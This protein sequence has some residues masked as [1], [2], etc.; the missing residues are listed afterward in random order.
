MR[1]ALLLSFSVLCP[2]C[3][4]PALA[5]PSAPTALTARS[6]S[7][8][9][10]D[11][12]WSAVSNGKQVL[13]SATNAAFTAGS[14]KRTLG[15]EV[16]AYAH[17]ALPGGTTYWYRVKSNGNG[18]SPWSNV[19]TGTTAPA[20]LAVR[21]LSPTSLEI[22][23]TANPANPSI[24]G[25]TVRFSTSAG[26]PA[27]TAYQ[28]AGPGTT[29]SYVA[30]ALVA[31]ATYFVA[32]KAEGTPD[33]AFSAPASVTLP[34]A[35]PAGVPISP[36]FFG[37]NAWMP[38][39]IGLAHKWGDLEQLLCGAGYTPGGACTPAEVQAS[40]VQ[41]MRYGGKTVDKQWDAGVSPGQYLT[42]V[43][44]LRAN[45]IEPI[46]QVPYDDG[47]FGPSVAA[48]LVST[49]N[50][51]PNARGVRYWSVGNEPNDVYPH[52]ATAAGIAGYV[53]THV[54]AMRA[55]SPDILI[56][57]PDLS[58][59]D[60]GIMEELMQPGGTND[61][62]GSYTAADGSERYYLD[63]VD[64]HA[65]PFHDG[66]QDRDQVIAYPSGSFADNLEA[67]RDLVDSCDQAHDRSGPAALRTAVTE[68]NVEYTNAPFGIGGVGAQSFLGGQFWAEIL[69]VG[70]E[71][72]LELMTF[73]SVK[74]G[75]PQLGY[76]ASDG[77]LL[78]S[79]YHFQMLAQTFRGAYLPGT[80][81]VNGAPHAHVK[82][83]ASHDAERTA[84]MILNQD[85]VEGFSYAVRLDGGA[86]SGAG[87]LQV[88]VDAGVAREYAPP[89]GEVL[90]PQG[91]VLLVFDGGGNLLERRFYDV[92]FGAAPPEV[93]TN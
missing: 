36:L 14:V 21:S 56:A 34:A 2:L 83:F 78:P 51:A 7:N 85:E 86:V 65:Y 6:V 46:L 90:P 9:E 55:V 20:G 8:A 67:L 72:G 30:E 49:I 39:W 15:A 57:G 61:L 29:S 76:I 1:T 33:S 84:V 27:G 37:Q 91:T 17:V 32:V 16:R 60:R 40:G 74:E 52:H 92:T 66:N 38:E 81:L 10:I 75:G 12:T 54:P 41:V 22:S 5:Q 93:R 80:A 87:A 35:V 71:H 89:A 43:D 69:S 77:T 23:W 24:E 4:V 79:Y 28:W 68:I 45:G 73:W 88:H 59:F 11:L 50:G 44:N 53:K 18:G 19:A 82:A 13:Q 70:M 26:F 47:T 64:F 62:C 25:Y 58:W 42:M 63:V 31:G 48:S 3:V